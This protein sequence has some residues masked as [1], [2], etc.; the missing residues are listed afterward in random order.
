MII[1]FYNSILPPFGNRVLAVFKNGLQAPPTHTFFSSND[2]LIEAA[3]TWDGLKKN[4]YHAC[5]AYGDEADPD[6]GRKLRTSSNTVGMKCVWLDLDVGPKKPYD[7]QRAAAEHIEA[8]RAELGLHKSHVVSSGGGVHVYFAFTK[9]I[10]PENWSRVA[11]M[12]AAC[13]DHFGVK[14]DTSRTEDSASILRT[15]GTANYKQ[16]TPRPVTLKRLGEE[17]PV[18]EFYAKLKAYAA[19]NGVVAGIKP[20]RGAKLTNDLVG[21]KEYPP[22]HGDL[23]AEH[24]PTI[25]KVAETGGDVGYNIWW[26]SVGVAKHTTDPDA[27]AAHWTRDRA[28]TGHEKNDW[29]KIMADWPAGPSTCDKFA[30]D[31]DSECANCPHRGKITSPIQLGAPEQ[32][33]VQPVQEVL[34]TKQQLL[35]TG[36]QMPGTWEFGADWI[37]QTITAAT[38]TGFSG[39][40]MTMSVQQ[41]DGTYKHVPFCDRYWQVMRRVRS[42]EGVWQLEIAYEDRPGAPP[43]KFFLNSADVTS[44]DS[45]RKEFSARELHIYGGNRAMLKTQEILRAEQALLHSFDEETTT[46]GHM[47]WVTENGQPNGPLT[48]AFVLGDTIFRPKAAQEPVKLSEDIP[49]VFR[50]GFRTKGTTAE[51]VAL[52]DRIYNRKDAQAYQFVIAAMFAAPL[53]K[54]MPGDGEWHGIPL[55]LGG[56]S[57]AAKTSTALVAMSIYGPGSILKFSGQASQGDTINA[58]AVKMGSLRNLPFIIDEMTGAEPAKVSDVMFMTANGARKDG[59]DQTG[60]L[61]TQQRWDT[62]SIVTSNESLHEVL[63]GLKDRSTTDAAQLRSF[64]IPFKRDDLATI[65]SDINRSTID[66]DLL[67]EQY[68]CVGRD[69]IQ[70]LVNNRSKIAA[71][72]LAMQRTYTLKN[73]S[74]AVRK[75]KDLIITVKVAAMLA[76]SKGFIGWDVDAMIKWAEDQLDS[77]HRRVAEHDWDS[78]ISEFVGSLIGRTVVTRHCSFAPG[79][80]HSVEIPIENLVNGAAPVARRALDDRVFFVAAGALQRWCQANK[81]MAK[82][83]VKEM[84]DRGLLQQWA[85]TDK[86]T[87]LLSITSG[88]NLAGTQAQCYMFDYD[89]AT[90]VISSATPKPEN[91]VL[92]FGLPTPPSVTPAVTAEGAEVGEASLSP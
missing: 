73:D 83:M 28:A 88:T 51:W 87:R 77:L 37:V 79:R 23:V 26:L 30:A 86:Q 53:V 71:M 68:G 39:G 42:P 62:L 2:D 70:F 78:A 24:C 14:H 65:F 45:L 57:G 22:S 31:P 18:A 58:L 69:W 56:D 21:T 46:Y 92:P 81:I 1:D 9:A 33:V 7:T 16:D 47:G 75:Y 50:G 44:T 3:S 17:V 35:M 49:L 38:R 13:L 25:R 29:Q 82:K 55:V 40:K 4:V 64:E 8:F 48:G 89:A 10:S 6:T 27:T 60:K 66:S 84:T 20:V 72:L 52:V 85:G 90:G 12:F 91:N 5:A 11:A 15:P 54:L 76:R 61:R 19:A 59:L 80:R 67:G 34:Q 74:S 36:K 32:P 63:T 41:E 43:S